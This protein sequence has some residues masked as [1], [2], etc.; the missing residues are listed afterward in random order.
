MKGRNWYDFEWYVR[1]RHPVHLAHFL[2]RAQESGELEGLSTIDLPAV[3][4][5]LH[6]RIDQVD[7][8]QAKAD[9]RPF[10]QDVSGLGLW[11]GGYFHDLAGELRVL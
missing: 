10:I 1:H 2:V 4:A 8:E 7:F 6:E 9:V 11:S 5:L 3:Q